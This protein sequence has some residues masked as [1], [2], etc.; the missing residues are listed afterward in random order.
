VRG[1]VVTPMPAKA[2]R[3]AV[4]QTASKAGDMRGNIFR[5]DA[6]LESAARSKARLIVLPELCISGYPL[7]DAK[8]A[9]L[10]SERV[11]G[12]PSTERWTEIAKSHDVCIVGGVCER[13]RDGLFNTAVVVGPDGYVGAYRKTHL[14]D[15]EKTIFLPGDRLRSFDT[16]LGRLGV[17]ICYDNYFP[18]VPSALAASGADVICH[19]L[20]TDGSF[21]MLIDRVRSMEN[22]V[23]IAA[24]NLCG[25]DRG[26]EFVGQS[27][28]TDA[29]GRVVA[30]AGA[31]EE[32]VTTARIS[33]RELE[34]ARGLGM[35]NAVRRD[36]RP[37]TFG[38]VEVVG[39]RALRPS[40]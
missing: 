25:S 7:R 6:L 36:R 30:S 13:V 16:P 22:G 1:T 35:R 26:L 8:E 24:A 20:A 12:G 39:P 31:S 17:M 21:D 9:R 23:V 4:L 29:Q 34:D 38:R 3:A 28:M 15:D 19:P 32:S 27:Q 11:P 40:S 10:C 33:R 37:E 14:W 5:T 2:Y 18:E